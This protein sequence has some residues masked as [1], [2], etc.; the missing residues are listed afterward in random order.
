MDLDTLSFILLGSIGA[1]AYLSLNNSKTPDVHP[2]ILNGQADVSRIRNAGESAIYR[3]KYTPNGQPLF[4]CPDRSARTLY[5][6]FQQGGLKNNAQA[7]F[8]GTR[9]NGG[10]GAYEWVAKRVNNFG[11]GL[12]NIAGLKTKSDEVVGI[13][14]PNSAAAH[15]YSLVTVP[16]DQHDTVSTLTHVLNLTGMTVMVVSSRTLPAALAAASEASSRALRHVIVIGTDE[17]LRADDRRAAEIAG[18]ELRS[19]EVVEKAGESAPVENVAPA[20]FLAI[21]P[22]NQKITASDRH[23]SYLSLAHVYERVTIGVLTYVGG[24]VAFYSG[25]VSKVLEDAQEAKPTIFTSVPKILHRV[26]DQI[27]KQ[28][29]DSFLYKKGYGNKQALLRQGRLVNDDMWD[30]LVFRDIRTKFFGGQV[31]VLVTSADL[32]NAKTTEFFRIVLGSQV[33]QGYGLVEASAAVTATLF[34]DYSSTGAVGA[35]LPCN[36]IKLIDLPELGYRAEDVPNPRGEILVRGHNVF[37]GY[38]GD[39]EATRKVIDADGWLRTGQVG[40][41]LP[42]GTIRIVDRKENVASRL[43]Q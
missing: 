39:E 2:L 22:P 5:D 30:L 35:P 7:N 25:D 28:Y 3:C 9:A 15:H 37:K 36:E 32:T 17:D 40:E 43:P 12:L 16:L 24:S 21:V 13:F 23:L 14:A 1:V 20:G 41:V 8:L 33:I 4:S 31:R 26:Q 18:I 19:F 10:K 34:N 11:S 42:N 38:L 27:I 29:G 6:I